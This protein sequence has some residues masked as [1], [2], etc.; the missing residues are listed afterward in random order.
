[1]KRLFALFTATAVFCLPACTPEPE[2]EPE[3]RPAIEITGEDAINIPAGGGEYSVTYKLENETENGT[4]S[5]ECPA[6]WISDTDCSIKGTV[7]FTVSA[8]DTEEER[9]TVLTIC[10]EYE[11]G[12][13]VEDSINII[14]GGTSGDEPEKEYDYEYDTGYL[15]GVYYGAIGENGEYNYYTW[16]SDL[17][18]DSG[19]MTMIG[20]TYYLF[21]IYGPEPTDYSLYSPAAGT[22]RLSEGTEEWTFNQ[23]SSWGLTIGETERTMDVHFTEG[24]LEIT[25]DD[26]L[27]Y[28]FEAFLTDDEG[29]SHHVT[30]TGNAPIWEDRSYNGPEYDYDIIEEDIDIEVRNALANYV[31]KDGDI[32]EAALI[33][34]DMEIDGEGYALPPG[35]AL[36]VDAY[37]PLDNNGYI[38]AG[39]YEIAEYPGDNF[40][41][42]YGEIYDLFDVLTPMGT[43]A[44]T[45]D[46]QGNPAYGLIESG[47]MEISGSDGLYDI[48]CRFTTFEGHSVTCNYSGELLVSGIPQG[49]STLTGDYTLDLSQATAS[50]SCYGNFYNTGGNNWAIS[51]LP[52]D[53]VT[54][55]GFSSDFVVEGLD[56]SEGIP[57]G[58]YTAAD[59]ESHMGIING[60][61]YPGEYLKGYLNEASGSLGGTVF[62]GG[63]DS[64]YVNEF[65][66]AIEGEMTITN[67]GDGTYT[68]QLDFIDD[69]GN[70]WGGEWSGEIYNAAPYC[71]SDP[72]SKTMQ[73]VNIETGTPQRAELFKY[74]ALPVRR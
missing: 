57:S 33:F 41:L 18:F 51:L 38:A 11:A 3:T 74:T 14:Q 66:P 70:N 32:M 55:D 62:M 44:V 31:I 2:P 46:G 21:D 26:N 16:L 5:A 40:S 54:G 7:T 12:E 49:F 25:I 47:T 9:S 72:D 73:T 39:T 67:H 17:P 34:T 64:G 30:Y 53:G 29:K 42:W 56:Q 15:T 24:T 63:F 36:T 27:N 52:S 60:A 50:A 13:S 35:T 61:V 37:M 23:V 65:A 20:G 8:N 28:T 69:L 68:I 59:A 45:Y 19:G 71:V 1:M 58:T 6:D 48:E 43:Y 22:Y 10:Y 4:V